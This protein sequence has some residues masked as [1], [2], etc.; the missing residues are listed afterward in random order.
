MFDPIPAGVEAV[1]EHRSLGAT[2]VACHHDEAHRRKR[3]EGYADWCAV[4]KGD[5]A[6]TAGWTLP[7]QLMAVLPAGAQQGLFA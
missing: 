4:C 6:T 7:V 1:R 3:P 2:L 5:E